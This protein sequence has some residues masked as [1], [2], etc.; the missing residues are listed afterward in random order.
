[1]TN[2]SISS[3]ASSIINRKCAL[4]VGAGVTAASGGMT[5][6]QLVDSLIDD[7]KY[8]SPLKDNFEIV[9]DICKKNGTEQVYQN[10]KS[11]LKNI[12]ISGSLLKLMELP[13]FSAFTTNYDTALEEAL[14][15]EQKL[16]VR[17]LVTGNEFDLDNFPSEILCIKLMGSVSYN[18][19]QS[20]SMIITKEELARAKEERSRIYGYLERHAHNLSFVF[21]GYSFN[22]EV[23]LDILNKLRAYL[24]PK[25]NKYYAIFRKDEVTGKEKEW[26]E[27]KYLLEQNG[28]L[29]IMDDIENFSNKLLQE[30]S[31]RDIKDLTKKR[32]SLGKDILP[33]DATKLSRFLYN[34]SPISFEDMEQDIPINQ[35]LKGNRMSLKPFGLGWHFNREEIKETVSSVLKCKNELKEPYIFNI[36]GNPG[37]G[38]TFILLS[39]LSELI[40]S[41]RSIGIKIDINSN[42]KIPKIDELEFFANEIETIIKEKGWQQPERIIFWSENSLDEDTLTNFDRL[43]QMW[44]YKKLHPYPLI[45]LYEDSPEKEYGHETFLSKVTMNIDANKELSSDK[46][47]ELSKYLKN[48]VKECKLPEIDNEEVNKI[49]EDEQTLLPILYRILDPSRRSI[50]EIIQQEFTELKDPEVKACIAL[51]ALASSFQLD[52]PVALL[53]NSL[54]D[55]LKKGFSYPDIF[56]IMVDKANKFILHHEDCRTNPLVSIYHPVIAQHIVK[57]SDEK[58]FDDFLISIANIIDLKQRLD[59]TFIFN[60]LILNGVNKILDDFTPF[61]YDGLEK[62]LLIIKKKQPARGI[63]H[64]IARMYFKKNRQ[65]MKIVPLLKEALTSEREEYLFR[66]RKENVYNTLGKVLWEQKK[67]RLIDKPRTDPE[68]VE[69]FDYLTLARKGEFYNIYPYDVHARI[70]R[71]IWQKKKEEE[72]LPLINEA[73]EVINEGL[74]HC[75][76]VNIISSYLNPLLIQ[77]LQEVDIEKA[78]TAAK[79]LFEQKG[80]GS[81]YYTLALN[82]YHNKA[83]PKGAISYLDMAIKAKSFPLKVIVLKI[84]IMLKDDNPNYD[85]LLKLVNALSSS[86]YVDDWKSAYLKAVIYT[87]MNESYRASSCFRYSHRFA[88]STLEKNIQIFWMDSGHRKVLTGKIGTT[89]TAREGR[90][91]PHNV[92]GYK[93]EIFFNPNYQ[94]YKSFLS[95]GIS[96]NFELGFSPRGPIALEV[97]PTNLKIKK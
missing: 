72:R 69:I 70:L 77:I 23:F 42:K 56:N 28:V 44:A 82:E 7:Y 16:T 90:I 38:R 43:N 96:I 20:G 85:E 30:I 91:F 27:K 21:M 92:E 80:D 31:L 2:G 48:V 3:M 35:F 83:N 26:E 62:A 57:I 49:I 29:I 93:G 79:D 4:F 9:S 87:I 86:S 88:P 6:T 89:F 60:L 5:W 22:D 64:H 55:Y 74:E 75:D 18:Y 65:D 1:M 8:K 76:E 58:Q 10:I 14:E 40:L 73:I 39:S 68:I 84:E 45:L 54:G 63:I 78:K 11:K 24:G 51:C 19:K 12:K 50:Q 71:E 61:T 52:F 25:G 81:G 15:S 36:N 95:Q 47:T 59:S 46:K 66:E 97:R 13:W 17:T 67:E 41:H 53:K 32:I 33:I 94:K 34:H 37:S